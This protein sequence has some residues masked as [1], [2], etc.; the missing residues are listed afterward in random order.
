MNQEITKAEA[1]LIEFLKLYKFVLEMKN[2]RHGEWDYI[3][4]LAERILFKLMEKA[5]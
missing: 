1:D 4:C 5:K 3:E 2:K